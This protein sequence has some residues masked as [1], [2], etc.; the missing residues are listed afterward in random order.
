M[1]FPFPTVDAALA[2]NVVRV[3]MVLVALAAVIWFGRQFVAS[4]FGRP[5]G[6]AYDKT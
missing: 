3:V 2:A 6:E 5:K 1:Q 4:G